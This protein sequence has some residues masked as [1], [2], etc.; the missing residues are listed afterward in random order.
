ME[1]AV[2]EPKKVIPSDSSANAERPE[3]L[4]TEPWPPSTA[5]TF[6]QWSEEVCRR[7][8]ELSRNDA[9]RRKVCRNLS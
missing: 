3:Q 9:L 5:E 2:S 4:R 6:E 8:E 7:M 1:T